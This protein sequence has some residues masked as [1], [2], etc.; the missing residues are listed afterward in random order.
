M[1]IMRSGCFLSAMLTITFFGCSEQPAS[2]D[3]EA[4]EAEVISAY[5]NNNY[6]NS[7]FELI[8]ISPPTVCKDLLDTRKME[9][10]A[11]IG[12]VDWKEGMGPIDAFRWR[13]RDWKVQEDT[14]QSFCEGN[15]KSRPIPAGLSLD[16]NHV[17]VPQER[18]S[19]IFKRHD[20]W[21]EFYKE[22]PKSQGIMNVSRVGLSSDMVEA[23][24]YVGNVRMSLDGSGFL[25][26][27]EKI[28]GE[29]IAI[30]R[31]RIWIS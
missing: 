12:V 17:L 24:L 3:R 31:M 11:K 15:A 22:Y 18:I 4:V 13:I 14:I 30:D 8:I 25:I 27:F 29:W 19:E 9:R 10:L 20:G 23:I 6:E 1:K 7:R 21:R 28:D 2:I 5:I 26:L 16:K